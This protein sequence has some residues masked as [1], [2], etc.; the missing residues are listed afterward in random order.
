MENAAACR[1]S[2]PQEALTL[3]ASLC[4]AEPSVLRARFAR[5]TDT[6]LQAGLY[7][8]IAFIAP[9]RFT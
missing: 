1:T 9:N 8:W 5:L 2:S 3:A 7:N 6:R 4:E